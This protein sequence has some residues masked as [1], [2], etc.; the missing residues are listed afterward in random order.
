MR[1][2]EGSALL[3]QASERTEDRNILDIP[4]PQVGN[5]SPMDNV[6]MGH[7]RPEWMLM[8]RD[9]TEAELR[10]AQADSR[11]SQTQRWDF[12]A[13]D[14][15]TPPEMTYKK[16]YK[17]L[18]ARKLQ[19][20]SL[21]VRADRIAVDYQNRFGIVIPTKRI[22]KAAHK[23]TA[24]L[25]SGDLLWRMLHDKIKTGSE[26]D[27]LP[28]VVQRCPIHSCSLSLRHIWVK[29]EVALE[30]WYEAAHI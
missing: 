18:M 17:L 7:L 6:N 3:E 28:E 19:D 16:A 9:T 30:V 29:C 4:T 5:K 10:S 26:L 11:A 20:I 1:N 13:P 12:E 24:L 2:H 8:L 25:K 27:W 21:D 22:W 23:F 14:G 15:T